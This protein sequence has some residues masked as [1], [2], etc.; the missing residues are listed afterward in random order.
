MAKR[1]DTRLTSRRHSPDDGLMTKQVST[2]NPCCGGP[3]PQGTDACCTRDAEAKFTGA[4]GCGC[5]SA[6][7]VPATQTKCCG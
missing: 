6:P 5:G 3:A 1:S 4:T 2:P 7:A